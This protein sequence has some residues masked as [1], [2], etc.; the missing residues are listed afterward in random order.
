MQVRFD[1]PANFVFLYFGAFFFALGAVVFLLFCP[2]VIK[3][4]PTY[5]LFL[6][7][8]HSDLEL[9]NWF[10][11]VS[12]LYRK[13]ANPRMIQQFLGILKG[14][15]NIT[16]PQLADLVN[17]KAGHALLDEF[18]GMPCAHSKRQNIY[19]LTANAA[20]NARPLARFAA[21]ISYA[22][23]GVCLAFVPVAN[24]CVMVKYVVKMPLF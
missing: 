9:K 11:Q 15:Q 23:G 4:A 18:W 10:H 5:G 6:N 1:I 13:D 22:V 16:T 12:L 3:L 17:D 21:T 24:F 14:N 8:R 20:D 19:D 7:G 2:A